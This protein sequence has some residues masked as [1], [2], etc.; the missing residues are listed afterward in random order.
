MFAP[1]VLDGAFDIWSKTG[2]ILLQK[3]Y[4]DNNIASFDQLV[5]KFGIP[6]PHF[7][8]YLQLRNFISSHSDCFPRYPSMTL[9]DSIFKLR[10]DFHQLI[11]RICNL[12]LH[13]L[14]TLDGLRCRREEDSNN[15]ISDVVWQKIIKRIYSSS[16]CQRHVVVQFKVGHQIH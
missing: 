6:R 3:L 14:V 13:N 1:S 7:F 12:Y 15:K 4:I 11:G 2:I 8:R 5:S 10:K 9:L 16:I